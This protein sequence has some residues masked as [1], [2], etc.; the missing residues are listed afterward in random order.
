M[1]FILDLLN[2]A[3]YLPFFKPD[4]EDISRNLRTLKKYEWFK[5]YYENEQYAQLIIHNKNVRKMLGSLNT[6][7]IANPKYQS[8]Y[9]KKIDKVLRK[10]LNTI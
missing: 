2:L 8:F 3:V 7:R 1:S 9:K 5:K 6:K 10:Q 4:E